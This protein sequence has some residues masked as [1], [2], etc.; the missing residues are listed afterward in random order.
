[1]IHYRIP[2]RYKFKKKK[3]EASIKI[4]TN[5]IY[6]GIHW[7]QRKTLKDRFLD[8]T[9]RVCDP[10]ESVQSYPVEI[11][12]RFIFVS[13]PLDTLNCA[14]MAKIIEDC[15][16]SLGI[17]EDDDLKCVAGSFIE[18]VVVPKEKRKKGVDPQS[19]ET[20]EENQDRVEVSII[21]Y[22]PISHIERFEKLFT[23]KQ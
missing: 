5:K 2:L 21:P 18:V 9:Q 22:E 4:S 17:I 3:G 16:R 19:A 10:I 14:Y 6:E 15:F 7:G 8:T 23:N 12:Y 20:D 11:W 13:R 1:M